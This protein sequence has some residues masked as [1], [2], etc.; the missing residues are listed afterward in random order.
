MYSSHRREKNE[1]NGG[2]TELEPN[3]CDEKGIDFVHGFDKVIIE[4]GESI[5]GGSEMQK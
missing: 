1:E 2:E 5:K 3:W 4:D